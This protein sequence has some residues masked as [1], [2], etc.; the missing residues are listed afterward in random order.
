MPQWSH[1]LPPTA[2]LVLLLSTI[3]DLK[4]Q[5]VDHT[6]AS[7][8]DE[9]TDPVLMSLPQGWQIDT[10]G[11]LQPHHDPKFNDASHFIKL[12]CNS[13]GC[14]QAA[15]NWFQFLSQVLLSEGYTQS[16]IDLC[17]YLHLGCLMV[18]Y[19]GDCLIF[20]WNDATIDKIVA[21]LS[22]TFLLED[23]GMV[24]DYLGIRIQTDIPTITISTT[25]N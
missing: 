22:K 21:N 13:Y 1:G 8:Q 17:L 4:S 15:R 7:P 23:Q 24:Q 12:K 2:H 5:Q 16:Q 19:M 9:L 25:N 6:Q 11:L 18:I 20:E 10:N 3:L 14:K